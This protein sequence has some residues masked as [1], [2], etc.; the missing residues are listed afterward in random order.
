[1]QQVREKY[2]VPA[3]RGATV[4]LNNHPYKIVSAPNIDTLRLRFPFREVHPTEVSYFVNG[5]WSKGDF[6]YRQYKLRIAIQQKRMSFIMEALREGA[7]RRGEI[8]GD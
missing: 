3:K 5:Y 6:L 4:M 1:M 2:G 7:I 8:E